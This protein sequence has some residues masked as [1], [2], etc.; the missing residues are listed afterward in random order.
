MSSKYSIEMNLRFSSE[1][2][3]WFIQTAVTIINGTKNKTLILNSAAAKN[4]LGN[5]EKKQFEEG[6]SNLSITMMQMGILKLLSWI[7][8]CLCYLSLFS[9]LPSYCAA[10]L[11]KRKTNKEKLYNLLKKEEK[12]LKETINKQ[13]TNK[14]TSHDTTYW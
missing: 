9:S 3:R 13:E 6:H 8:V 5:S 7:A 1:R 2:G 12:K 11:W 14:F 4:K 10:F